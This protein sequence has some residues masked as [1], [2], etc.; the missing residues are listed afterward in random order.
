MHYTV[1]KLAHLA[2]ISVRTLH[3]YDEI[4]LLKPTFV[5]ENGY[6]YYGDAELIRLQQIL[7]FR[8]LE[9]SL[10][11]IKR[12]VSRPDFSVIQAL[13]EQ[14]TLFKL[15]QVK[16]EKLINSINITIKRMTNNQKINHEE[17]YDVFKDDDEIGRAHV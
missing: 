1:N 9:F 2:G 17:L 14:R 4:G 12:I 3:Y 8:E 13:K 6:R 11:D 5:G 16:L 15:K 7:F 10:E